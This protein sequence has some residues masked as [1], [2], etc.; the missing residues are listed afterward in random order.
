MNWTNFP[1][2][3]TNAFTYLEG[4]RYIYSLTISAIAERDSSRW[5]VKTKHFIIH[6]FI[7]TFNSGASCAKSI[8]SSKRHGRNF[9]FLHLL[10][11]LDWWLQ[12]YRRFSSVEVPCLVCVSYRVK[13]HLV[14][15]DLLLLQNT[16]LGQPAVCRGRQTHMKI[17]YKG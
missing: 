17:K 8:S 1:S 15:A 2:P 10:C 4:L 14:H 5:N 6:I 11:I 7:Y 3:N 16:E 9:D 12:E 13:R